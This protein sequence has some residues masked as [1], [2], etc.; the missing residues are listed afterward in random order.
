M[1]SYRAVSAG[2]VIVAF[3]ALSGPAAAEMGMGTSDMP[4]ST[5]CVWGVSLSLTAQNN[6]FDTDCLA[7][8]PGER[9][10]IAFENKDGVLHNVVIHREH[11]GNAPLFRGEVIPGP[12]T[13]VYTVGPLPAGTY[14]FHCEVHPDTMMGRFV[15]GGPTAAAFPAAMAMAMPADPMSPGTPATAAPAGTQSQV[16]KGIATTNRAPSPLHPLWLVVGLACCATGLFVVR[17]SRRRREA[18]GA[19]APDSVAVAGS[20]GGLVQRRDLVRLGAAG[21]AGAAVAKLATSQLPAGASDRLGGIHVSVFTHILGPAGPTKF[22]H[23]WTFTVYGPDDALNGMGWGG[24][25]DLKTEQDVFNSKMFPCIYSL[26]GAVEGDLVKVRG[27]MLFSGSP[28]QG[29]PLTFEANPRTGALHVNAY[30][31]YDFE[32]TGVVARI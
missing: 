29:L 32:G 30:N 5:P 22:P 21:V 13:A 10:T 25:T 3:W 16:G 1:R 19:V 2:F 4:S 23:H 31:T 27:L 15:L 18:A 20:D 26:T 6:T 11:D 7:A 14:H 12:G 24:A 9:F 28:D 8:P 17:R